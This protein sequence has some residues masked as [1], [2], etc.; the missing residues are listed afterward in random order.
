MLKL[1]KITIIF[2]LFLI[3][4]TNLLSFDSVKN[5]IRPYFKL[6]LQ[7]DTNST[8]YDNQNISYYPSKE[9]IELLQEGGNTIF[10]RHSH[11][12][13][14]EF[15]RAFDVV[16]LNQYESKYIKENNCLTSRGREE[17]KFIG[18]IFEHLKIPLD[19]VYTSPIC[20]CVETAKIAF[21]K[22]QIKEFL[23]YEYTVEKKNR[24]GFKDKTYKL[25]FDKPKNNYNKIIV[26]HGS[27]P[28]S[29][30]FNFPKIGQSGLMIYNHNNDKISAIL[31]FDSFV[32]ALYKK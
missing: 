26:A 2:F 29:L 1:Y 11:K 5:I 23:Q 14:S 28:F 9:I 32:H 21:E 19:N 10:I 17:A 24:A 30:G 31:E 7:V 18:L 4:I 12:K 13:H 8:T 22:Y 15:Q 27:T 6:E 25:F 16:E 3:L 20:R